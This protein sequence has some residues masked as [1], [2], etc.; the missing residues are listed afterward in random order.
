MTRTETEAE[1]L[2]EQHPFHKL[3]LK[4]DLEARQKEFEKKMGGKKV[5]YEFQE[6]GLELE[7]WFN[8]K[9]YWIFYRSWGEISEVRAA[10]KICKEKNIRDANYLLAILTPKAGK[11]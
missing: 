4:Y 6:V 7:K 2:T 10:L 8:R 5:D 3:P 1:I 9:L 11:V